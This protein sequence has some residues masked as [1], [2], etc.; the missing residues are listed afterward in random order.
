MSVLKSCRRGLLSAVLFASIVAAAGCSTTANRSAL[1]ASAAEFP[2]PAHATMPEGVFVNV[3]NLRKIAPG[4]T[5]H[6]LYDLLGAPHFDEGVFGVHTWNYILNFRETDG[7]MVRCQYQVHFDKQSVASDFYWK[8]AACKS[9][10]EVRA[11]APAPVPV[12]VLPAEP[13]RLSSDALFA[14]DSATLTDTGKARLNELLQQV[15]SASQIQNVVITGYTDRIG[16]A[17]YNL[18]LSLKRAEAVRDHLAGQGVTRDSMRV[19]GHGEA[20]PLVQCDDKRR[21]RL[22]LCLAPNRRVELKGEARPHA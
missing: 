14:F 20:D 12:A 19:E 6:Q 9:L 15:Q 17:R 2:D 10:I 18:A 16:S 7:A 3:E 1:G 11:P 4:M 8:P 5:K 13:I 22:I 21:D